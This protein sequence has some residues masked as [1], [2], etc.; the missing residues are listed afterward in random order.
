MHAGWNMIGKKAEP[1]LA[2]F[3]LA[4]LA[5]CLLLLLPVA[6]YFFELFAL[7]DKRTIWLACISGLFLGANYWAL[8]LAYRTGQL[9]I[10]YPVARSF[11][12]I[13]VTLIM[14]LK[15]YTELLNTVFILGASMIVIGSIILPMIHFKDFK[16]TNYTNQ[17]TWYAFLAACATAGYS[18]V[19]SS[20]IS[21]LWLL[22]DK[23]DDNIKLTL[24]YALIEGLFASVWMGFVLI[25]N[26]KTRLSVK[27]MFQKKFNSFIITGL[28]I[29]MTYTLVLISMSMVENVS[30]IVAFRQVSIPVGVIL[31][32]YIFK[33]PR[34]LPKITGVILMF[35]GV[36]LVSVG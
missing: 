22:I 27:R 8:A 14:L 23:P 17:A 25:Y 7:L 4:N 19:D 1:D 6:I 21:G 18:I 5:G 31:G 29:H 10:T 13:I 11:P 36:V 33:E 9:S 32:V 15:G 16:I 20:S 2:F 24:L 35:S 34:T 3:F 30:Y 28:A 12:V 26:E